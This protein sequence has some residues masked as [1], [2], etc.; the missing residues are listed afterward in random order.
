M[1]KMAKT[2]NTVELH[3]GEPDVTAEKFSRYVRNFFGILEDVAAGVSGKRH[4]IK[5][6]I[7]VKNES[8]GLCATP[9]SVN[10][11]GRL[12]GKTARAISNGLRAIAQ[13]KQKPKYWSEAGLENLYELGSAT[14]LVEEGRNIIRIGRSD[15]DISP[16]SVA[17]VGELLKAPI[18]AYGSVEGMLNALELSGRLRFGINEVLTGNRIHC[19]FP[20]SVYDDVI[21]ALRQRVAAYGII[22]YHKNGEPKNIEIERITVFPSDDNLPQFEDIVGLYK[23]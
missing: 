17:H 1:T 4:G 5:W 21:K 3:I 23:D 9:R 7:S 14:G 19:F 16:S 6:I 22:S 11:N 12:S 2:K 13:R 8:M 18:R 20:G 15:C 10:G